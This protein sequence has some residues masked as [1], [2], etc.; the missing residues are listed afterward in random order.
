MAP[1]SAHRNLRHFLQV[2]ASRIKQKGTTTCHTEYQV[3][4]GHADVRSHAGRAKIGEGLADGV[5]EVIELAL[6]LVLG[7]DGVV[8]LHLIDAVHDIAVLLAA[9]VHL[10][11][12]HGELLLG[13]LGGVE[14]AADAAL[15]EH[16][17]S[18]HHANGLPEWA[19]VV[20]IGEGVLLEELILDDSRR[21]KIKRKHA[22]C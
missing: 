13:A 18:L 22:Q 12:V 10:D 8:E 5:V 15:V 6:H 19:V 17:D 14:D 21:L 7:H 20:V 2:L 11:V 4:Y 3:R 9:E 1:S 16:N